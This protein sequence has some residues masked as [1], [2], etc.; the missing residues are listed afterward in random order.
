MNLD[1][2]NI[3]IILIIFLIVILLVKNIKENFKNHKHKEG[4]KEQLLTQFGLDKDRFDLKKNNPINFNLK[5]SF[6][7]KFIKEY[8]GSLQVNT[9]TLNPFFR[10]TLDKKNNR[11]VKR[12][13]LIYPIHIILLPINPSDKNLSV[14]VT[15][16]K[17]FNYLYVALFNNGGL[18]TKLNLSDRFWNGPLKNSI[19]ETNNDYEPMR[20]ISLDKDGYLLGIDYEGY[21][22]KKPYGLIEPEH[23]DY[24]ENKWVLVS[25]TLKMKYIM[26]KENETYYFIDMDNNLKECIYSGSTLTIKENSAYSITDNLNIE[27]IYKDHTNH[28]LLLD[29]N[30]KLYKSD[31]TVDKINNNNIKIDTKAFNPSKLVDIIYDFDM[32]LYGLALTNI[33]SLELVKQDLV[34]YLGVFK[35][36]KENEDDK[37]ILLTNNQIINF[38]NNIHII[39]KEEYETLEDSFFE[40]KKN[41]YIEFKNFC[42]D[43]FGNNYIDAK[44]LK[45]KEQND[46]VINELKNLKEELLDINKYNMEK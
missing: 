7:K 32:K 29:E 9:T 22:Y 18:Y 3:S 43:R 33:N 26:N 21:L 28:L 1:N 17:K 37:K 31:N 24:Y 14:D 4:F 6:D 16:K 15:K 30:N 39:N 2:K 11:L 36:I 27:K 20:N 42:K 12:N 44:F 8:G 25:N 13:I 41:D 23:K 5:N 35:K 40:Q 38:K 19:S 45:K 34:S 10:D 46:D